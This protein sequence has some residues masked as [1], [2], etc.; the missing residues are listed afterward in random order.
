MTMLSTPPPRPT[1]P[2]LTADYRALR[3]MAERLN[4]RPVPGVRMTERQFVSWSADELPAEW[5]DGEVFLMTTPSLT[6]AELSGWLY[7]FLIAFV[8]AHDLGRV[9]LPLTIRLAEVPSRRDPDLLF[10][11]KGRLHLLRPNHLEGPSDLA[12]EIVS[13]D[14]VG[15]DW[16]TKYGE[17]EAAGVREYWIVDPLTR[18]F[19]AHTLKGKKYRPLPADIE[20]RVFPKVLKGLH[21]RPAWLWTSPLPKVAAILKELGVR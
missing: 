12:V 10:V 18:T 15:R 7:R 19:E 13:P 4:G 8:E 1:R 14:S 21:L 6:H 20:G 2:P 3:E 17:Y 5:V 9:L 16:R 11:A